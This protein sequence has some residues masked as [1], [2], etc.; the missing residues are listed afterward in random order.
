[1]YCGNIKC[2]ADTL[3]AVTLIQLLKTLNKIQTYTHTM[4]VLYC[5]ALYCI[6]LYCIVFSCYGGAVRFKKGDAS[7]ENIHNEDL[8]KMRILLTNTR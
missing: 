5:T 3:S 6:V 1:M 7:F 4:H 2:N 8:P